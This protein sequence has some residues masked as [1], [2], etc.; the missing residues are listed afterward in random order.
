V[1][2]EEANANS[3]RPSPDINRTAATIDSPS[4]MTCGQKRPIAKPTLQAIKDPP[5]PTV[6]AIANTDPIV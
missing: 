1:I 5:T 3:I 6:M 2:N 4:E